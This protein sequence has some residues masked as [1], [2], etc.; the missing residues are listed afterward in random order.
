M[1]DACSATQKCCDNAL[2]CVGGVCTIV[3]K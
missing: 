2:Q 3:I 1:D